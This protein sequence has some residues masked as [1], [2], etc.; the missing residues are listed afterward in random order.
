MWPGPPIVLI[1]MREKLAVCD[2]T[3][4]SIYRKTAGL[5]RMICIKWGEGV[6]KSQLYDTLYLARSQNIV[7]LIILEIMTDQIKLFKN[8]ELVN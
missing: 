3:N 7:L 8:E 4:L 5:G 6:S 1:S 2:I